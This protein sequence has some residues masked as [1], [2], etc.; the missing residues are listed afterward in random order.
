[1]IE[2]V[3]QE[4]R[5]VLE[6]LGFP[7]PEGVLISEAPAHVNAELSL[8]IALQ[9]ARV[10][11]QNPRVLAEQIKSALEA[12]PLIESVEIA[13]PG[14][15]NI[16]CAA[17]AYV[18]LSQA[19]QNA[20]HADRLAGEQLPEAERKHINVEYVSAN[21][22]GPLTIANARGGPIGETVVQVLT[23]RGHK[24]TR[25]YYVNDIGGQANIFGASVLHHYKRYF[26]LESELPI[27][28][29]PAQYV[30][31]L[32]AEIA[33]AEG[34]RFLDMP[35]E[36]QVDAM[37][38][39]AIERM[40]A[41]IRA[42]TERMGIHFDRWYWQST[43]LSEGRSQAT[44]KELVERG[45]TLEKDGA[46]WL[47]SGF[48]DDDRETVLVKQDGVTTYFLDDIAY[49]REK[50]TERGIDSVV[51][52]LGA[53]HSGHVPRMQASMTAIGLKAEQYQ[54]IIYQYVQLKEDG[55]TKK[56]AKREGTFVTADEVLDE[57]SRDVFTYFMLSKAN[58]THLDFDMQLAKDTSEKNPIYYIQY[59]HA[60]IHS[61][62]ERAPEAEAG[63]YVFN[64]EERHLLRHLSQFPNV[65]KEVGDTFRVHALSLYVYELATRYHHFYAHHRVISDDTAATY[66]RL[67]LSKLTAATIKKALE[68][69]N[70]SAPEKM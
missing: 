49:H 37:R 56:M 33:E 14:F 62:L 67:E 69:M 3:E 40:I 20:C 8:N 9:L 66:A 30:Q 44:F 63:G 17:E 39:D 13:G 42:T 12:R 53:N 45:A 38:A 22:S 35:E 5:A 19:L 50:F 64:T 6:K 43:L 54:A 55:V 70:I 10:V 29:Y 4:L 28:G 68:L 65:V 36:L 57:I 60:R 21:P 31:D 41:K 59:A 23:A 34:K 2:F 1:M 16:K 48:H 18:E 25:D 7:Y 11:Q 51:C 46:I 58:E 32:A 61:I 52:T 15:I 47:K 24:V 26:G 27:K